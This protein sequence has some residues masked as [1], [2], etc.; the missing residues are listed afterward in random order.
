MLNDSVIASYG[1][2]KPLAVAFKAVVHEEVEHCVGVDGQEACVQHAY[3]HQFFFQS[4]MG[5]IF[6]IINSICFQ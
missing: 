2:D 3:C 5:G 4:W 1:E 6:T